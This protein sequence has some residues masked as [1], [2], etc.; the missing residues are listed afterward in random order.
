MKKIIRR[1]YV[2][3]KRYQGKFVISVIVI[4]GVGMILSG[5][6]FNFLSYMTLES[7]R[8]KTHIASIDTI[9]TAIKPHLVS[10]LVVF[11]FYTTVALLAFSKYILNR[12]HPPLFRIRRDID[13]AKEG[14]L[15]AGVNL[16][17]TEEFRNTADS[18]NHMIGSLRQRFGNIREDFGK[19]EKTINII[20]Y[21][22]DRPE[23]TEGKTKELIDNL[24]H[25]KASMKK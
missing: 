11:I 4:C 15:T 7:L 12:A 10:S 3:D 19:T 24:E 9:G 5:G 17:H 23:L 16:L 14:N 25:L 13:T 22:L 8:W 18:V 2:N 20:E 1:N 21:V 6:M